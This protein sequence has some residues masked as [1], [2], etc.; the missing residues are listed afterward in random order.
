[1]KIGTKS[2]NDASSSVKNTKLPPI[3]LQPERSE[4]VFSHDVISRDVKIAVTFKYLALWCEFNSNAGRFC[5]QTER[6]SQFSE[7]SVDW[8]PVF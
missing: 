7:K 2:L 8:N 1:M 5:S 4:E 6:L 3:I